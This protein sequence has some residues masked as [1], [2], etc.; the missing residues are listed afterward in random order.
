M[1]FWFSALKKVSQGEWCDE[2]KV[3][4]IRSCPGEQNDIRVP[5]IFFVKAQLSKVPW[6]WRTNLIFIF[7]FWNG[8]WWVSMLR[9]SA[10]IRAYSHHVACEWLLYFTKSFICFLFRITSHQMSRSWINPLQPDFDFPWPCSSHFE[11]YN[12]VLYKFYC[13]FFY[14]HCRHLDVRSNTRAPT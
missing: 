10:V 9:C 11:K 2:T 6:I 7:C 1:P 13:V 4:L 5:T 14:L 12:V 8:T 3:S